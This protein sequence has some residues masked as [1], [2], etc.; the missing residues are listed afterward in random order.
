MWNESSYRLLNTTSLGSNA[1][2]LIHNLNDEIILA[3]GTDLKLLD[4]ELRLLD[5]YKRPNKDN[6]V[7]FVLVL[8]NYRIVVATNLDVEIYTYLNQSEEEATDQTMNT[9]KLKELKRFNNTHRD[10]ILVL[11]NI[12]GELKEEE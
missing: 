3:G 1:F 12:S 6:L 8:N 10:S 5:E 4:S 9:F 11:E 2:N 7:K